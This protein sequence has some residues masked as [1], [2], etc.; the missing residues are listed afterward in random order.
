MGTVA[1]GDIRKRMRLLVD[2]EPWLV[3][4]TDFVK[5]G[6]GQAFMRAK[7]KNL[8]NGR[9]LERTYKSAESVEEANV[10]FQ[11]MQYLYND[12][13]RWVFMNNQSYEQVE[14]AKEVVGDAAQWLQ[15]N[16]DCEIA[17]WNNR[18]VSVTP[19][20]FLELTVTYTEPAVR[21]DTATNV[22]KK[23]TLETGAEVNVPLFI[24]TGNKVKID[25]RTGEY[26]GRTGAYS[27]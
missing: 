21:G 24:E 9:V 8:I 6:K 10:A 20:I 23:A 2:G 1:A 27:K 12:G 14:V 13:D 7:L 3:V 22:T 19:P 25:T 16:A 11:V 4:D 15:E 18:V 26:L 17:L 5:P